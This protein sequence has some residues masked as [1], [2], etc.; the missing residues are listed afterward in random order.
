M[1]FGSLVCLP[2]YTI[3]TVEIYIQ[4]EQIKDDFIFRRQVV[5]SMSW[6]CVVVVVLDFSTFLMFLGRIWAP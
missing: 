4:H 5:V 3:N 6:F 2:L 1:R